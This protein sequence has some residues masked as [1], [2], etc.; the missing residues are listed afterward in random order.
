MGYMNANF[1]T[2]KMLL[3]GSGAVE[4]DAFVAAGAELVGALQ[5]TTAREPAPARFDGGDIR[6]EGDLEQAHLAFAFPGVAARDPDAMVAQVF[7]T[8]LGGGMSSRLFQEAREKRGLCYAISAFSASQSDSGMIGVYAGTG[9]QE[10]G[11]IAPLIASEIEAM[12][13]NAS[14]EEVARARAQLAAALLMGFESPSLRCERIAGHLFTFGRVLTA[15]ESRARIEAVDAAKVRAFA[16]RICRTGGPAI[17]AVGPVGRLE[18]RETFARR[19]GR[20][21]ALAP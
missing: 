16:E 10:A 21:A 17:A 7:A 20:A 15:Q 9:P 5:R 2:A 13:Q 3:I 19:F 8:A 14:E 4:H 11:E 12:A 1:G 6:D 18:S